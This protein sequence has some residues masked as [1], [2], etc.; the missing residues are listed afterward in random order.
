MNRAISELRNLNVY[1]RLASEEYKSFTS[2]IVPYK[3][4]LEMANAFTVVTFLYLIF[5]NG[6]SHL[7]FNAFLCTS[8]LSEAA[9]SFT[10]F[11]DFCV[12][13]FR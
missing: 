7:F 11:G 10:E 2:E 4:Y 5:L 12:I 8:L 1:L 3:F 9:R 6:L 13:K